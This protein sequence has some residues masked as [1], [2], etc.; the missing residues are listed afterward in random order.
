M[1]LEARQVTVNMPDGKVV[2]YE[3]QIPVREF[4]RVYIVGCATTKDSVPY[5]DDAA[6]FWGVNNLYGVPLPGARFSR[7]FEIHNIWFDPNVKKLLRRGDQ[8]FRGQPVDLYMKG[9]AA[10]GIPIYMQQFWPDIVPN[11]VPYPMA[12]MMKFYMEPNERK[13]WSMDLSQARYLTNTIS[14]EIA[15]AIYE[16]FK[17]IQIWGVDMAVGT[18]YAQQRP[19]CEFWAGVARG[20]GINVYIPSEADLLKTRFIYGFEEPLQNEFSKKMKKLKKDMNAKFGNTQQQFLGAQKTMEQ[21][22]GAMHA[23]GEIEKI[24]SNLGDQITVQAS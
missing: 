6:E 5:K 3:M 8:D 24:W 23:I 4:D 10:L 15:L 21:Y 11:S 2:T 16:G 14:L 12:D 20:M 9:L 1:R 7:W 18:E 17:E 19:S 13:P 22:I